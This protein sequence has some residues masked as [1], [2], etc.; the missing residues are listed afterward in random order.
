MSGRGT[1]LAAILLAMLSVPCRAATITVINDNLPGEGLNDPTPVAALPTNPELTLGA[2]RLFVIQ[3]AADI[4]AGILESDVE[5]RVQ[6]SFDPLPCS[7]VFSFGGA[8][9]WIS[10]MSDFPGAQFPATW[11]PIALANKLAGVDLDPG[12]PS[13]NNDLFII[14]NSDAALPTCFGQDFY[15]GIDDQHGTALDLFSLALHEIGHGLGFA[16]SV[17]ETTGSNFAGQTDIYSHF[18]LDTTLGQTWSDLDPGPADDATR[19]ASALRCGKISWNGPSVTAAVPSLLDPGTPT[20]TVVSPAGLAGDYLAGKSYFGAL[21]TPGG[22]SSEVEVANDGTG[23]PADACEPLVGFTP[24]NIALVDRGTCF[25][26]VKA[27]NAQ[28]AGAAGVLVANNIAGCPTP[29]IAGTDPSITIP[30]VMISLEDGLLL[31]GQI[32]VPGVT[33]TLRLDSRPM[34]ADAANHALLYAADPVAPASSISHWDTSLHPNLVM[35]PFLNVDLRASINGVDLTQSLM[36]DIGW[37]NTDLSITQ[38]ESADP[39]AA[40]ALFSYFLEVTNGGSGTD[41]LVTVTSTLPA[42][43]HFVSA[44]GMGW[45]CSHLAGNVTCTRV[46][47]PGPDL[48]HGPAPAITLT[49]SAP[50]AQGTMSHTVSVSSPQPLADLVPG[51]NSATATTTV[52]QSG[53]RGAAEIPTLSITGWIVFTLA[54]LGL[55]LRRVP[56]NRPAPPHSPPSR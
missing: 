22:V 33:A 26:V 50:M 8:G 38:S 24:G 9:G 48:P 29:E 20:L 27:A 49:L 53:I 37:F 21:L 36:R 39:V 31:K 18:T 3:H 56:R 52:V 40:G 19:A 5:I 46:A 14:F 11:Y 7:P 17:D 4:W 12:P 30:I 2:Q 16:N 13:S 42:G 1:W 23:A 35:E 43:A 55:A 44:V 54:L 15:L 51:N 28:A 47:G 10:A 6:A 41:S 32:P 25:F 34:G 45:T